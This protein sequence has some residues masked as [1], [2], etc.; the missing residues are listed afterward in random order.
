MHTYIHT[1]VLCDEMGLGKTVELL[2]LVL[3]TYI[4]ACIHTYIHTYIN[5]HTYT[6]IHAYIH[7]C[8]HTGVLCDEMGLGKTVELLQLVLRTYIH[9]YIHTYTYIHTYMH[10]QTG[11]LC[12][13]MGLGKTVELLQLVLMRSPKDAIINNHTSA[14][15]NTQTDHS[16]HQ[17]HESDRDGLESRIIVQEHAVKSEDDT[18]DLCVD[19]VSRAR[20]QARDHDMESGHSQDASHASGHVRVRGSEKPENDTEK[21]EN[22]TEKPENDTEML[23][24]DGVNG[25]P[26]LLETENDQS[27]AVRHSDRDVNDVTSQHSSRANS[28]IG[29]EKNISIGAE[30]KHVGNHVIPGG[31]RRGS[32]IEVMWDGEWWNACVR[33]LRVGG[34]EGCTDEA[35]IRFI[36]DDDGEDDT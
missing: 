24:N 19:A 22:D 34:E 9:A 35:L 13:E 12:D 5:R 16:S 29:A 36:G 28:C 6:H 27:G 11:V 33:A 17:N 10:I 20:D 30:K 8:I 15:E 2:Q 3:R 7:A 21:P 4:H 18:T 14:Q 26:G 25:K 23:G 32:K 31:L 1:G